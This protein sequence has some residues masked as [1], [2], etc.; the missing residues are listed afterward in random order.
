GDPSRWPALAV[1]R[2]D[3]RDG[4]AREANPPDRRERG[5]GRPP[6]PRGFVALVSRT[7]DRRIELRLLPI[8]LS[9]GTRGRPS[10]PVGPRAGACP[11]C[12]LSFGRRLVDA[13]NER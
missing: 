13:R 10:S 7:A 9:P 3:L 4:E 8:A 12:V 6:A 1:V 2:E 5:G 11:R